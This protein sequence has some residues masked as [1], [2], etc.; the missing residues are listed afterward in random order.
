[1]RYIETFDGRMPEYNLNLL[2]FFEY[3]TRTDD[4]DN[5]GKFVCTSWAA[6]VL[7]RMKILRTTQRGTNK[8]LRP[9]NVLLLDFLNCSAQPPVAPGWSY[10]EVF[11][12]GE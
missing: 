6:A 7:Q 1:M 12:I 4:D 2:D 3:G 9:G 8:P 5:D 10:G 11:F